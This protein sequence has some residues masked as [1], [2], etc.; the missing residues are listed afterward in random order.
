M[1]YYKVGKMETTNLRE[2]KAAA[3]A[4]NVDLIL[5]DGKKRE[6]IMKGGIYCG[7][8]KDVPKRSKS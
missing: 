8:W 4:Q 3:I 7:M 6:I 5:I 1:Y 2:A